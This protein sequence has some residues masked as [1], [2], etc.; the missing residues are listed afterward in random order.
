MKLA[1]HRTLRPAT[2]DRP[3]YPAIDTM[4]GLVMAWPVSWI[5]KAFARRT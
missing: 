4:A 3:D 2:G 5:R 1:I